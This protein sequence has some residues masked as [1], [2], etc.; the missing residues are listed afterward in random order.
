MNYYKVNY[1]IIIIQGFTFQESLAWGALIS[2]TDPVCILAAFKQYTTDSN[3]F[4]LVFGES[5]LNDAVSMVFYDSVSEYTGG[6]SNFNK[7]F[8]PLIKF[9]V[10]LIGSTIVGILIGF[11]ASVILK[12]QKNNFR[13]EIG[14]MLTFPWFSYLLC[15]VLG[16]SA[17]VV[18]FFI[19][20]SFHIYAKPY[21]SEHSEEIIHTVYEEV[22]NIAESL[23][24]VFIGLSFFADHPYE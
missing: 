2:A 17:I 14:F 19:G 4:L 5:I 12:F 23:V 13:M 9:F 22:V 20:V 3:F 21:I 11:I 6:G 16:L 15:H 1:F 24:F 8:Y 7:F 10:I 18:I